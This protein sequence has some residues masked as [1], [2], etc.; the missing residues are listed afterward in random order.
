MLYPLPNH[1]GFVIP[2]STATPT[3][4]AI[5]TQRYT[6]MLT[7]VISFP[8]ASVHGV[9][10]LISW[11]YSFKRL[12]EEY[13]IAKKKKQALDK[14]YESGRISEITRDSFNGEIIAAIAEIE[15]QQ[16]DL[17]TK[18]DAKVTEL[19]SQIQTLE[20]L[21]ANYEIQHVVGEVDEDTYQHEITLLTTGLDTSKHELDTIKEAANQ[22]CTPTPA[23]E[24]L[25]PEP[26]AEVVAPAPEPVVAPAP[27]V[28]VAPPEPAIAPE[29]AP[30]IEIPVVCVQETAAAPEPVPE[31]APAEAPAAVEAAPEAPA[32]VAEAAVVE[33]PTDT[34]A[35]AEPA[36]EAVAPEAP[37]EPAITETPVAEAAT[38]PLVIE[39]PAE[40]VIEPASEAPAEPAPVAEA[41]VEPITEAPA[42]IVTEPSQEVTP[43]PS[44][45]NPIETLTEIPEQNLSTAE[46]IIEPET[47]ETVEE[48]TIEANPMGAPKEAHPEPQIAAAAETENAEDSQTTEH[49]ASHEENSNQ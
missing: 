3:W 13:D 24:A 4:S 46:T 17:L 40:A 10:K 2:N 20:M 41:P 8:G 31:P 38:E 19:R 45:E 30:A 11:K 9:L 49:E 15:H 43:E 23:P 29:P 7:S 28:E 5:I 26:V 36:A 48:V 44:T 14:L 25:S 47:P 12:N 16:K 34:A 1:V 6:R 33:A 42:E 35:I 32:S 27:T 37:T 22:L 39:V 21:L 18:M